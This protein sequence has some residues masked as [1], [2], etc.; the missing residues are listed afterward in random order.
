MIN[1]VILRITNRDSE[2]AT[3]HI[4]VDPEDVAFDVLI[5][6]PAGALAA[7]ILQILSGLYDYNPEGYGKQGIFKQSLN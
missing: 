4:E 2:T 3:V 1:S 5:K 7:S 6:S